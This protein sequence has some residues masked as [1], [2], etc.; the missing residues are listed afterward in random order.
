MNIPAFL[1][2]AILLLAVAPQQRQPQP[3]L[4]ASIE[5]IV[6]KAGTNEPIQGATVELTGIAPRLVDG[7]SRSSP[8]TI[9]VS[10][11]ETETDG[12]VLS[13]TAT[14]DRNGRFAIRNVP[15]TT[16]YQLVAIHQPDY[17][18][19]Q[20]G[21][22]IPAVPGQPIALAS[23]Q[24]LTDLRI[25]MTQSGTI[26]GR[27]VDVA[28][29]GVR[30]VVVELRRPWY[31]EGWRLL[32]D[33]QE[34]ISRVRGVGRTNRAGFAQTNGR[35]EF[36][37][38]GLAPAH[39]YVRAVSK[40]DAEATRIHLRAGAN[41]Q[42]VRI[43][44]RQLQPRHVRGVVVRSG[45]GTIVDSASIAVVRRDAVPLYQNAVSASASSQGG[46]FDVTIREPGDYFVLATVRSRQGLLHGRKAIRVGDLDL[47]AGRIEIG[48]AF[49]IA[50]AVVMEDR[51]G[52][53]NIAAAPLFLKLYALTA[54]TP[55]VAPVSLATPRRTF[56]VLGVTPGDYRVEVTPIL[57]VP[58]GS[59]LPPSLQN[60]YVKAI[61]L[62]TT[63][64]L[65][66]GL[67]LESAVDTS[68]EV[69][70]SMHGGTLDGR[71]LDE[72]RKPAINAAINAM[73]VL[74][75]D[76]AR[77]TRGDL[78]RSVSADDSGRFQLRGLPPG[79]YK[80]F[81]WERVEDGAWQDP[82]FIRLYE[83]RGAPV[84]ITED[85]Q[86]TM[87]ATLIPAWN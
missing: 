15:P 48:P 3:Q 39:Y 10:V 43:V 63:D 5:G 22:R 70:I 59:L 6:V 85:R 77:R 7:S 49:D 55:P 27:V 62:G 31:L 32:A 21:Q 80:L 37:F 25:E 61:R 30:N 69:I 14:T 58:P 18:P 73:V 68:L 51:T 65:N 47:D 9:S 74:V 28:G 36:H 53:A 17:V 44:A 29:E 76:L 1:R 83:D 78:Y 2:S 60:A 35:G 4:P 24:Q 79:D 45:T 71:A 19:A 41:I 50:G 84:R 64:V 75:P 33:W 23:G 40:N 86:Q 34:T 46:M 54:G 56:T 26:S 72:S 66:G 38:E 16:G 87:D 57:S 67:H 20:Y 8:G 42:N 13:F 52:A 82:E 12:R 81:A 11:Q